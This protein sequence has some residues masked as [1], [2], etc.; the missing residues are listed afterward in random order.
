MQTLRPFKSRRLVGFIPA[1]LPSSA[2][3][4]RQVYPGSSSPPRK[5]R[6]PRDHMAAPSRLLILPAHSAAACAWEEPGGAGPMSHRVTRLVPTAPGFSEAPRPS[7]EMRAAHSSAPPHRQTARLVSLR[8][9]VPLS[10]VLKLERLR[11]RSAF[12]VRFSEGPGFCKELCP[13]EDA[14]L[15]Q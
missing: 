4:R 13:L 1:S 11:T 8:Q 7:G 9:G 10:F 14:D 15:E 5:R 6:C 2:T 3:L 12:V